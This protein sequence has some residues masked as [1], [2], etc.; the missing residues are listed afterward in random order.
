[1]IIASSQ[2][3]NLLKRVGNGEITFHE[4][5]VEPFHEFTGTQIGE[6]GFGFVRSTKWK[7]T[8][9]AL[10]VLKGGSTLSLE[11]FRKEI[12][13]MCLVDHPNL[14]KCW[15]ANCRLTS[16]EV[17]YLMPLYPHNLLQFILTKDVKP[18]VHKIATNIIEGLNYL[19]NVNII[20][21]DLKPANVLITSKNDGVVVVITD[22][23]VS[24]FLTGS[25]LHTGTTGTAGFRAPEIIVPEGK[26]ATY[27]T[28][29]DMFSFAILLWMLASGIG[30]LSDTLSSAEIDTQHK[31]GERFEISPSIDSVYANLII[32][33][34]E[35]DAIKR[36]SAIS[37][38]QILNQ[39]STQ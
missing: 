31:K 23:G 32:S 28:K 34:W 2:L 5:L 39:V 15:R 19:H 7:G 30:N 13:L 3:S 33:C 9:A 21:R 17:G 36:P 27:T 35:Q 4:Q 26:I 24:K 29:T 25:T 11:L 38:L 14:M 8:P 10:K 16:M 1:M 20:H 12:A 37:V 22:F 6:G 18:L